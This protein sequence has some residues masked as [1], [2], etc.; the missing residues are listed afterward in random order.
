MGIIVRVE[1]DESADAPRGWASASGTLGGHSDI[2]RVR[3][4]SR[5]ARQRRWRAALCRVLGFTGALLILIPAVAVF[6]APH[7]P[8][9]QPFTDALWVVLASVC[10]GALLIAAA[11]GRLDRIAAER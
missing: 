4:R 10:A 9:L 3:R 8:N 1:A 11:V 5:R 2:S 7:A 6:L